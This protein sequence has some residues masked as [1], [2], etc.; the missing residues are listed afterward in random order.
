MASTL[1][2]IDEAK[3]L[4]RRHVNVTHSRTPDGWVILEDIEILWVVWDPNGWQVVVSVPRLDDKL[5]QAS[6]N[7]HDHQT[8][9]NA[10]SIHGDDVYLLEPREIDSEQTSSDSGLS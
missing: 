7:E 8:R 10:Y 2:F 5:Y 3:K 6:Y 4:I 1:D 9:V